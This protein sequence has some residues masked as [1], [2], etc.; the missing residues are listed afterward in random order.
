MAK[1]KTPKMEGATDYQQIQRNIQ[2]AKGNP[3]KNIHHKKNNSNYGGYQ[4]PEKVAAAQRE[5][6]QEEKMPLGVKIALGVSMAVMLLM[7]ILLGGPLKG[8]VLAGH[9]TSVLS[10]AAC[11]VVF[12]SQRWSVHK[13]KF[14]TVM[15]SILLFLGAIFICMGCYGVYLT[16]K[17]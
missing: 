11:L 15:G 2:K 10:G 8:N 16:L 1:N 4:N 9:I 6:E 13:S 17:G 3:N 14:L 5:R 7:V 12:Y